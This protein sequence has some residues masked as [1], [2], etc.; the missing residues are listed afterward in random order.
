MSRA[1]KEVDGS[2]ISATAAAYRTCVAH[3]HLEGRGEQR[4]EPWL[5]RLCIQPALGL[6][7]RVRSISAPF[8]CTMLE[9][10]RMLCCHG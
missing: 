6:S 3:L 4:F 1:L 5:V 2:N 8:G 10:L 7:W 9:M